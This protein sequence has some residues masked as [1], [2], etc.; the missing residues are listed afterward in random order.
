[1]DDRF[2]SDFRKINQHDGKDGPEPLT[3]QIRMFRLL[4]ANDVPKVCDLP[5]GMGKTS[6]IHLWTLAL[7]HQISENKPRLPTRLIYVVDRRT[8]VDQATD[9]AERIQNNLNSLPAIGLPKDWLAV[10]TLRGQFADN[11]E[12]DQRSIQAGNSCRDG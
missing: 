4:C 2:S 12:W 7:R 5:A 9:V 3:W 11:R 10:S 1:L 6:I 8:V